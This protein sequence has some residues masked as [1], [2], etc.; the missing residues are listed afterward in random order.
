MDD[1]NNEQDTS[2]V[3]ITDL[4]EPS[5]TSSSPRR[6]R[7]VPRQYRVPASIGIVG[8]VVLVI[9]LIWAGTSSPARQ[10]L[11]PTVS[12]SPTTP[13][14]SPTYYIQANPPWGYLTLDGHAVQLPPDTGM[15]APLVLTSGQHT[16][17]WHAYPFFDQHCMLTA[18]LET[19]IDTCDHPMVLPPGESGSVNSI[20]YFRPS[21]NLLA[22]AQ[23]TALIQAAQQALDSE[24]ST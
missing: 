8:T 24:E 7:F 23:R 4:D 21:L 19:G 2:E 13:S 18:P 15:G 11:F 14:G 5:L 16:L 10:L 17:V 6:F 12:P 22:A 20:I 3:E 1:R 9:L